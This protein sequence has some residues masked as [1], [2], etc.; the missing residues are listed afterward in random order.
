MT[1]RIDLE[2]TKSPQR[3]WNEPKTFSWETK[4]YQYLPIYNIYITHVR[5]HKASRIAVALAIDKASS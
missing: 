4:Q 2:Y 1:G 5:D 3:N